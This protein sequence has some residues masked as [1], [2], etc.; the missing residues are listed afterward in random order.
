MALSMDFESDNDAIEISLS[1]PPQARAGDD[2]PITIMVRNRQ[3]RTVGLA[4]VGPEIT[5]D[6]VIVRAD[7]SVWRRL[8]GQTIP[9]ALQIRMLEP[10][11]SIVLTDTWHAT[12]AAGVY[13]IRGR[14]PTDAEPLETPWVEIE[15]VS[16]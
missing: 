5:F 6:I 9:L 12:V 8:E 14:I 16:G 13:A 11:A 10:G 7:A 3:T 1:A 15:I 2:V 4:S